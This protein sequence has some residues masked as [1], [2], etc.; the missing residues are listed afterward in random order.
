LT[1]ANVLR[2]IVRQDPDVLLIGEIRDKETADIAIESALTGHLVLST[3]H[4]NDAPGA[5]TRMRDLGI[6]S[7]LM[8]DSMLAV[9]AQRLVRVLC[10]LCKAPYEARDVD[11]TRLGG[12]FPEL[13]ETITLYH[14][15]GCERC[16]NTGFKGRQAIFEVLPITDT[17]RS[18]IVADKNAGAISLLGREEGYYPLLRHGFQKVME[19]N[20]T[21]SEVLRVTSLF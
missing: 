1:F 11:R 4:T 8:A 19:G 13:P 2:S 10:P 6:E 9:L 15:K 14:S 5:I 7:F 20:T 3:L 12:V 21:L 16:G 18:A 17:V